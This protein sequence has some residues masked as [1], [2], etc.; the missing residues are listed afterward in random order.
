[1]VPFQHRPL[2]TCHASCEFIAM[3]LSK[4]FQKQEE[5]YIIKINPNPR[6]GFEDKD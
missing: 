2:T 5:L 3:L 1:M 6:H 4:A